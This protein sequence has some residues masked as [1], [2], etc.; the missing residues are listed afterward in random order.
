MQVEIAYT[1]LPSVLH[2]WARLQVPGSGSVSKLLAATILR[3][4]QDVWNTL[5]YKD[6]GLEAYLRAALML[7]WGLQ[8]FGR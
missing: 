2:V 3:R 8:A 5:G 6:E 7:K 4:A 1:S